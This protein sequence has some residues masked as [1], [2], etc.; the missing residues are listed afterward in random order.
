[1]MVT[2][3]H[4]FPGVTLV[5]ILRADMG[6]QVFDFRAAERTFQLLTQ[7]A[8]RAGRG[9][10]PGRVLLQTFLPEHYAIAA[11]AAQDYAAFVRAE[12]PARRELGYP[13]FGALALLRGEG[14]EEPRVV[15]AMERL[16]E[17][18]RPAADASGVELL[19]PAPAPLPRLRGAYRRHLL[20]KGPTR[21]AVREVAERAAVWAERAPR[22]VRVILDIDPL[23]LV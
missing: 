4:D 11:A 20:L 17:V 2:K 16:A 15:E 12:L 23:H 18:L 14:P 19:G 8:G 3:G 9:E 1:Q 21:R 13:P 7:V 22:G 5:G 10:E 6:L